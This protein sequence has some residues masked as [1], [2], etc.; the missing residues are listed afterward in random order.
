MLNKI[1]RT[2]HQPSSTIIYQSCPLPQSLRLETCWNPY[3]KWW[4]PHS[5][6]IN[7]QGRDPCLSF[8][9]PWQRFHHV[10][11]SRSNSTWRRLANGFG[12]D[13][14]LILGGPK[15]GD[16][17]IYVYFHGKWLNMIEHDKPWDCHGLFPTFSIS[18]RPCR[19]FRERSMCWAED[20][21][22]SC[23][24]L[25]GRCFVPCQSTEHNQLSTVERPSWWICYVPWPTMTYHDMLGR[26]YHDIPLWSI[27]YPCIPMHN[28]TVHALACHPMASPTIR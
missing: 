25:Q 3:E 6:I 4:N 5:L 28:V 12:N 8:V 18:F 9:T 11:E 20:Q 22:S 1:I 27:T 21:S 16:T 14:T 13:K 23:S 7:Q 26:T 17:P 15:I 24:P 10:D 19:A 2:H